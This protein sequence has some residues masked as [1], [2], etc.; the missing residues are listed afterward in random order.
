MAQKEPDLWFSYVRSHRALIREIERRLA[1]ADLPTY[2]WY[3]ILWGVE[4]GE[5]GSRRMHELADALVIERYNLTRIVDRMERD[6]LVIRS[7]SATDG[8]AAF[9]AITPAGRDLRKRMWR[10]YKTAIDELFLAQFT[11]S[12][13]AAMAD[14][15]DQAAVAANAGSSK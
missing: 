8:R 3:D 12:D 14:A 10:I 5:G 15:L 9:V 2:A 7:R 13:H 6:G 4:S 11:D 1:E